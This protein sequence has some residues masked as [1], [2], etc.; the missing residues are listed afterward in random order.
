MMMQKAKTLVKTPK[1]K[2]DSKLKRK[3]ILINHIK[4]LCSNGISLRD[5]LDSNPFPEKPFELRGSEEFFDY[6]KFNNY[7]MVKQDLE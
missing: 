5:F 1:K 6:V 4:Y 3:I 2:N 7:E